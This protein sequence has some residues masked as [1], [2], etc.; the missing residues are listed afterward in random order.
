MKLSFSELYLHLY[1][2]LPQTEIKQRYKVKFHNKLDFIEL[3][4]YETTNELQ[5]AE[6]ELL[7]K[8]AMNVGLNSNG[9]VSLPVKKVTKKI[10]QNKKPKVLR[11]LGKGA[12]RRIP[13]KRTAAV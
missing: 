7:M 5:N 10:V 4:N 11:S 8:S 12:I 6:R 9:R 2:T 1:K 13:F 3:E